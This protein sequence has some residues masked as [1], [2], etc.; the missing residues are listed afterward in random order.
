MLALSKALQGRAPRISFLCAFVSRSSRSSLAFMG[1]TAVSTKTDRTSE[2][3]KDSEKQNMPPAPR[4]L[5]STS[6][7][8]GLSMAEEQDLP[9][10]RIHGADLDRWCSFFHSP[11]LVP[12]KSHMK[13]CCTALYICIFVYLHNVQLH[14]RGNHPNYCTNCLF[15]AC[16]C[17]SLA[18]GR[19]L[20][21]DLSIT[22][23]SLP[24]LSIA[25]TGK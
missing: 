1:R 6:C 11:G 15:Q 25:K 18:V 22:V 9:N 14:D 12:I 3:L 8:F 10:S 24:C 20:L 7:A 13:S 5:P 17:G 19:A 2:D 23:P 16:S 4:I 21:T